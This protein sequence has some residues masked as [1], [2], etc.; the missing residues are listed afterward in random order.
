MSGRLLRMASGCQLIWLAAIP[1]AWCQTPVVSGVVDAASYTATLGE[2]GSIGSIFGTNLAAS[3]GTAQ[4]VPL[5]KQL[6]GT[7]VTWNG[8][9]APLFYVSPTQINFQVPSELGQPAGVNSSVIVS[10]PAGSSVPFQPSSATPSAWYVAGLF[11]MDGSGCGQGAVLNIANDGSGSLNSL[12]NSASPGGWISAYGTG[13]TPPSAPPDGVATPATPLLGVQAGLQFDFA[14]LEGTPSQSW[15][16][17]APGVVGV[18]QF[19]A[20][21]PGSVREGCAVPVQFKYSTRSNAISQPV[22]LAIRQGGG[23]C[24][25]PPAAGYGQIVWQRTV[26]TTASNAAFESDTMTVSLQSSPGKQAPPPVVYSDGCFLPGNICGNSLQ[27]TITYSGPSCS[28]PGYR[29]LAAGTVTLQGPGVSPT[30][31]PVI[32]FQQGQ[33]GGLSAYQAGL[34][35]GAIQAGNYTVTASG[36]ADVGAFQA[37][38]QVGPDIQIQTA[39]AGASVWAACKP[40]TI[41]WTGGDPNS[42]V[43]VRLVQQVA[44]AAGGYQ[45]TNFAYRTPTSNGVMTIPYSVPG[46]ANGCLASTPVTISV[47][48][49]PDPSKIASFSASGLALGGQVTWKYVHA[50]SAIMHL[51]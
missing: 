8:V 30:Q 4:V 21:I 29:S 28:V 20:Q 50:F 38:V 12:R 44:A 40:F 43:T 24:V 16:G 48:V 46:S 19:N 5:P 41:N 26:T 32:P 7:T 10:T 37:T 9:A 3:T 36:G 23:P 22:T 13:V 31:A 1:A 34:P 49:N 11:A 15:S 39:L 27:S 25:D 14:D 45:F 51:D 47:E 6:V 42:W 18:D 33:L 2:P 17:L 35:K